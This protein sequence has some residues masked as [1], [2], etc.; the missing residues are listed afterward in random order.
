[1]IVDAVRQVYKGRI[2]YAANWDKVG[3][4]GFW[5]ALDVIGVHAYFPLADGDNPDAETLR[6]GWDAPLAKPASPRRRRGRQA[7]GLRRDRLQPLAGRGPAALG[8]RGSRQP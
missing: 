6:R 4:V 7:G 3:E 5:D 2:T 1:M 8:V